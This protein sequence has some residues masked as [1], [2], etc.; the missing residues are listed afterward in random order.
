MGARRIIGLFGGIRPMARQMSQA[1]GKRV[2]ATTIQ[3]WS[4]RGAIPSRRQDEV[5]AAARECGI[6]LGFADFFDGPEA[7]TS[8]DELLGATPYVGNRVPVE[9]DNVNYSTGSLDSHWREGVFGTELMT[10][11]LNTSVANPV[12]KVTI[13]SLNDLGYIVNVGAA[14]TYGLPPAPP[15]AALRGQGT[16]LLLNDVWRGPVF[17]V[18]ENG[19]VV[20]TLRR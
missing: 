10:P 7:R 8:F 1:L 6:A 5:M 16:I 15:L 13:S 9:N 3:G 12:S 2:P 14:E 4:D 20:G 19:V 17:L 18:D 11:G